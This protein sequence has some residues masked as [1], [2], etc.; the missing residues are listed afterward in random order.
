M[1]APLAEATPPP[2][3]TAPAAAVF[4][5][6]PADRRSLLPQLVAETPT[7][8]LVQATSPPASPPTDGITSLQKAAFAQHDFAAMQAAL[9]LATA[10]AAQTRLQTEMNA[11]AADAAAG[12]QYQ[13]LQHK[14]DIERVM[15]TAAH[16][17]DMERMKHEMQL[18]AAHAAAATLAGAQAALRRQSPSGHL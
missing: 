10:T 17:A 18:A 11:Q 12:F 4:A 9:G 7:T 14:A 6:L 8:S 16:K 3:P 15:M 13:E 1:A 2:S 5:R